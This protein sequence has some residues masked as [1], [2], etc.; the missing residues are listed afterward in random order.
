MKQTIFYFNETNY[1][2]FTFSNLK[3]NTLIVKYIKYTAI[4]LERINFRG[5]VGL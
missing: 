2:I 4:R 3:K 5:T 1:F